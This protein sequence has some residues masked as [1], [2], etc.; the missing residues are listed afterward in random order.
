MSRSIVCPA[1]DGPGDPVNRREF[2]RVV[3]SAAVAAAVVTAAPLP[4]DRVA[5]DDKS[6]PATGNQRQKA[7]RLVDAGPERRNLLRVGFLRRPRAAQN[8]RFQ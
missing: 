2:V 4:C 5:A 7:L 3:G 1:C 6:Q 8:A